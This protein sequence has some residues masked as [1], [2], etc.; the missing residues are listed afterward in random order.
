MVEPRGAPAAEHLTMDEATPD[1]RLQRVAELRRG[2]S[3]SWLLRLSAVGVILLGWW[4]WSVGD[5]HESI[6]SGEQKR[7]NLK[8][9][10]GKLTPAPVRDSRDWSQAKPW[11]KEQLT[12][13]GGLKAVATTF[14]LAT[15]A[16]SLSGLFALLLLPAAARNLATA[17]PLGLRSGAAQPLR[18]LWVLLRTV[19][20]GLFVFTR[21]MPEYVLGFLIISILGPDPW[22]LV[23]ALAVHNFGILGR[24][25]SE[26]IENSP[27]DAGR[28]IIAHGGG[29]LGAYLAAL[30]PESFNRMVVYFFYRWETCV[31]EAT[32]LGMLGIAS[33][34]LLITEAQAGRAFDRMVFFVLCGALIVLA[35]DLLSAFVRRTLRYQRPC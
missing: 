5:I 32:V 2:R 1:S 8:R 20:Q 4:A 27:S 33:L 24:L 28:T 12:E 6:L 3:R 31:R 14:G 29:R 35:G 11:I 9:F 34:G 21:A 7:A 10:L 17:Q 25:G 23:L 19:T 26:V 15:V 16:A 30:L 22:T 18:W 13:G